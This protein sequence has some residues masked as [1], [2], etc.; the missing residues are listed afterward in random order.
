MQLRA[1]L[2]VAVLAVAQT[3]PTPAARRLSAA[4]RVKKGRYGVNVLHHRLAELNPIAARAGRM[5]ATC[6]ITARVAPGST[7]RP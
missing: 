2:S 7:A 4:A 3:N 5:T 6:R 1:L